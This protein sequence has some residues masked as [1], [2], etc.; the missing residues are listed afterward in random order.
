[1]SD[2][3]VRYINTPFAY[4]CVQKGLTLLQ[5]NIMVRVSAHLQGYVNKFFQNSA[6][7]NSKENP[8][9]IMTEEDRLSLLPVRIDFSELGVS[10]GSYKRVREALLEILN[11]CVEFDDF[12]EDGKPIKVLQHLFYS[13]ATPVTD[14]GTIVRKK[15]GDSDELVD[16]EVDRT[17]GYF[18]LELNKDAI[19]RMFDMNLGY[20]SHPVDIANV[21]KVDN[22]PL[23]YYFI[24]HKMKNFKVSSAKVTVMELRDY[25]GTVKRD[26]D[27]TII[28]MQYQ[29]YSRFKERIINTALNDI[30]RICDR[31]DIDFYFEMEEVRANGKKIG[32]PS[33]LVFRKIA[34]KEKTE[35]DY[36][37]ASEQKLL[38]YFVGQYPFMEELKLKRFLHG[39]SVELWDNFKD[40]VYNDVP[41]IIERPHRWNGT[42]EEFVYSIMKHWINTRKKKSQQPKQASLFD[43]EETKP[44]KK[45]ET[46]IGEGVNIWDSFV[47]LVTD[48]SQKSLLSRL[49]FVGLKNGRFCIACSDDDFNSIE[50]SGL[51]KVARKFFDCEKSFAPVFYRG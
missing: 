37:K 1:M 29:K 38:T 19:S 7:L 9:P 31:G 43:D 44:I 51:E 50:K 40:Y 24:R 36:R 2:K 11:V 26:Y 4:V 10:S 35:K 45:I 48:N 21:G 49:K 46:K 22:M 18:E 30:K 28:K 14:H 13:V 12:D 42:Q 33:Y 39:I 5:Q 27:G 15:I 41:K 16:V 32:D 47:L 6:L 34:N 8:K 25:L 23:M 17:R 3:C 20:V